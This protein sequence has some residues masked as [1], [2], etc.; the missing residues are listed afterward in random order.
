MCRSIAKDG[1]KKGGREGGPLS[2]PRGKA[3]ETKPQGCARGFRSNRGSENWWLGRVQKLSAAALALG[4]PLVAR[5]ATRYLFGGLARVSKFPPAN[6]ATSNNSGLVWTND[7]LFFFP[8]RW[9]TRE[10]GESNEWGK[11]KANVATL[12]LQ[13]KLNYRDKLNLRENLVW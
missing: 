11:Y 4:F 8:T 13:D 9:L 1:R 5:I 12:A 7:A 2:R 3:T 6:T 10:R